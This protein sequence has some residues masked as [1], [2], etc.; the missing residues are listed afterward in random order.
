MRH[1]KGR[2]TLF[3]S[4]LLQLL[5]QQNTEKEDTRSTQEPTCSIN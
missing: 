1:N 5:Q 4:A 3:I 2:S